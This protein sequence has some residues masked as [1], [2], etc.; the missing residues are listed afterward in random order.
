MLDNTDAAVVRTGRLLRTNESLIRG[1]LAVLTPDGKLEFFDPSVFLNRRWANVHSRSHGSPACNRS[2][3]PAHSQSECVGPRQ[4]SEGGFDILSR[5]SDS[6]HRGGGVR[7]GR[8][9]GF[10]PAA[11]VGSS[12]TPAPVVRTRP[13]GRADRS[14]PRLG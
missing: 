11:L 8:G 13:R 4:G 9:R 14:L 2:G 5:R 1:N 3:R 10:V 6:L 7:S 12:Q